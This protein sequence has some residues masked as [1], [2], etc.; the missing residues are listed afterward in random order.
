MGDDAAAHLVYTF[1]LHIFQCAISLW[2]PHAH[3]DELNSNRNWFFVPHPN[4]N[5]VACEPPSHSIIKHIF[6]RNFNYFPERHIFVVRRNSMPFAYI[7]QLVVIMRHSD[8]AIQP[9]LSRQCIAWHPVR[10]WCFHITTSAGKVVFGDRMGCTFC[11][12][13][14][15]LIHYANH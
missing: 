10:R 12:W 4:A 8:N 2:K 3:D 15:H 5:A 7:V 9:A 6:E 13:F 11:D 1:F 14:M